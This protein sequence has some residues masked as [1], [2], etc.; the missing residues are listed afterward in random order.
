MTNY[1]LVLWP[2]SQEFMD[3]EWFEHEA[4]LAD[5]VSVAGSAYFIP[6]ER[7][8]NNEYI[9]QRVEELASQFTSTE[10]EKEEMYKAWEEMD[11]DGGITTEE[12]IL[13]IKFQQ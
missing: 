2:E 13:T 7:I 11:F 4:F 6:E 9:T 8:I 1:I 3:E 10:E 12:A 5:H